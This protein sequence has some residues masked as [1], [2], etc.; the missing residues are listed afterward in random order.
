M[1]ET[2]MRLQAVL[3]GKRYVLKVDVHIGGITKHANANYC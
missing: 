1:G 2:L 3:L